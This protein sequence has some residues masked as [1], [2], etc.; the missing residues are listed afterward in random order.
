MYIL[1]HETLKNKND[2]FDTHI[3]AEQYGNFH[4]PIISKPSCRKNRRH[5]NIYQ[6]MWIVH[7]RLKL[8]GRFEMHPHYSFN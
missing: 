4:Q 1:S 2:T 5:M 6:L 7:L 3:T 8:I